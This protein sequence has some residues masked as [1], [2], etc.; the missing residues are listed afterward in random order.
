MDIGIL[1]ALAGELHVQADALRE[2][3]R[4]AETLR[5]RTPEAGEWANSFGT[6]YQTLRGIAEACEAVVARVQS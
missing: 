5:R 4:E 6:A 3:A 2:R 1:R